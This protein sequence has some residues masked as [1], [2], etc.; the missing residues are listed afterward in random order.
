MLRGG[1]QCPILL[2]LAAHGQ[3]K[4]D[5]QSEQDAAEQIHRQPGRHQQGIRAGRGGQLNAHGL[6]QRGVEEKRKQAHRHG[7]RIQIEALMHLRGMG[8]PRREEEADGNAHNRRHH[9]PV[10][11]EAHHIG[12]GMAHQ[13][14]AD[15]RRNAGREQHGVDVCAQLFLLHQAVDD[16]AQHRRPDVQ[17]VDAPGA[18]AQGQHKCQS[19]NIIGRRAAQG[20]QPQ[21]AQSHQTHIQE[22]RGIAAHGK[23]VGG[24]FPRLAHDLPQAGKHGIPVR[25]TH[26][27]NEKRSG[28]EA[29]KQLQKRAFLQIF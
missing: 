21:A 11:V 9:E 24:N 13:Q 18:E 26:R 15:Q 22:R 7:G 16:N 5:A 19:G 17:N 1:Q 27:R 25:H 29:E 3:R 23:I 6:E 2:R 4:H 14:V 12:I 28:K 10:Q 8:Q 20:I